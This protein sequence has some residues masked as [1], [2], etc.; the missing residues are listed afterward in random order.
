[1]LNVDC[2]GN[3]VSLIS[4]WH[5]YVVIDMNGDKKK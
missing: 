3:C 1:M 2:S 4:R 5:N